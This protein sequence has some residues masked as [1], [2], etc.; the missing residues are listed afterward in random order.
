MIRLKKSLAAYGTAA[1]ESVLKA[2]IEDLNPSLLPLQQGLS[3][4]SYVSDTPFTTVILATE[5]DGHLIRIKTGIFYAGIIAG[6]CCAD[7]PTPCDELPEYCEL[8]FDIDTST[9]ES[10]CKLIAV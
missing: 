1:F 6:S 9:G 2:E 3:H 8:I 5:R 7:D 10:S 4:S